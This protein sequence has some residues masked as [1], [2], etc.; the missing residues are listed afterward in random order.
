M[1]ICSAIQHIRIGDLSIHAQSSSALTTDDVPNEG[2]L[3]DVVIDEER[4]PEGTPDAFNFL[5]KTEERAL[6]RDSTAA[7][8]GKGSTFHSRDVH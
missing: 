2:A 4:L 3:M 8:S 6:V 1:F 5:S 7:F